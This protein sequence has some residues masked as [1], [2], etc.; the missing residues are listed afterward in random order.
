MVCI[1]NLYV[2][3]EVYDVVFEFHSP[4]LLYNVH[5]SYIGYVMEYT[6]MGMCS[7]SFDSLCLV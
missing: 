2:H 6:I 1:Y 3:V 5:I 4:S 7:L